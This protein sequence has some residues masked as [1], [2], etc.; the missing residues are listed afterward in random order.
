MSY[1]P[2]IHHLA[3][4]IL[5]TL[6]AVL[7]LNILLAVILGKRWRIL[8]RW[9]IPS[10]LGLGLLVLWLGSYT[11]SPLLGA[12]NQV[13]RGF[14]VTTQR[15]INTPLNSGDILIT[16][17]DSPVAISVLSNLSTVNCRWES[18]RNGALD[19]SDSCD[20][21]YAAPQAENDIL[22]VRVEPGC[23]LLPAQGKLKISILP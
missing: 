16:Q 20:V 21:I 12:N 11:Y 23:K 14:L 7:V 10:L 13:L 5:L 9:S 6:G 22:T 15:Q 19:G 18:L 2:C 4:R 1:L 8:S 3:V 17:A